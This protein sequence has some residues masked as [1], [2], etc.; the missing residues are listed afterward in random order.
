MFWTLFMHVCRVW[1][2]DGG[3]MPL[4]PPPQRYC[5]PASLVFFFQA[6]NGLELREGLRVELGMGSMGFGPGLG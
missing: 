5:D 4:P 1:G 6:S 3:W 2:G